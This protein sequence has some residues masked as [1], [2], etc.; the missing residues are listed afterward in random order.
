MGSGVSG[1][2]HMGGQG[3]GVI[4]S[5]SRDATCYHTLKSTGGMGHCSSKYATGGGFGG[6]WI[7]KNG[8]RWEVGPQVK[9]EKGG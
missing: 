4:L 3:V 2:T 7:L 5:L 6:K 1:I 9:W 8:G